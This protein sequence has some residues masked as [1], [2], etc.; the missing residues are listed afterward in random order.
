MNWLPCLA[1]VLSLFG[2]GKAGQAPPQK[3]TADEIHSVI[4]AQPV[5]VTPEQAAEVFALGS[6]ATD[7]QRDLLKKE[8]IGN[9]IVWNIQVYEIELKGESYKVTSQ[10]IPIQPAQAVGVL[11]VVAFVYPRNGADLNA[12]RQAK[13]NDIF[14][15][16]GKVQDIE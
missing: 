16:R 11:R 13:T 8:L 6:E 2:C 10:P 3:S 15:L 1:I 9:V 12:L 5:S 7:L 14:K 4:Q